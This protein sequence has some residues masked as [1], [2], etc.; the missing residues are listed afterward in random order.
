MFD[1]GNERGLNANLDS[2]QT[3]NEIEEEPRR[4]GDMGERGVK[5][6]VENWYYIVSF[7]LY[8]LHKK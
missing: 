7:S 5:I 4:L 3:L 1:V 6:R 2:D 8:I